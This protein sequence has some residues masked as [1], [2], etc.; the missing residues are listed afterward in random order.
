MERL[1]F[2]ADGVADGD[3]KLSS[4]FAEDFGR[5]SE[6][7]RGPACVAEEIAPVAV[8]SVEENRYDGDFC[9]GYDLQD[10]FLPLTILEAVAKGRF[11]HSAGGEEADGLSVL[12]LAECLTDAVDRNGAFGW[13]VGGEGVDGNEVGA[14]GAD[15]VEHHVD[16]HFELRPAR[17]DKVDERDA[18]E[19]AE[20][21]VAYC[22]ESALREMVED[23][24]VVDAQSYF[25]FVEKQTTDEFRSGC[26]A[27]VAV[28]L[29]DFVDG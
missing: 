10:R 2:G 27:A 9:F 11:A 17:S 25:E 16:Q 14:H 23:L 26:V 24:L 1:F 28:D 15:F 21:V 18:V 4:D 3:M 5:E 8:A 29:I 13:V 6:R 7:A 22:D 12:E 20:G 19:S